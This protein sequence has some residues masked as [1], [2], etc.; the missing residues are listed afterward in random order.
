VTKKLKERYGTRIPMDETVISPEA[1]Y[2]SGMLATVW[3]K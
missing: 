3:R 2:K 1:I